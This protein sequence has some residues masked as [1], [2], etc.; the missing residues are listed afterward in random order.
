MII[1]LKGCAEEEAA[2][3]LERLSKAARFATD[4]FD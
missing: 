1:E 2:N 4:I 3:A